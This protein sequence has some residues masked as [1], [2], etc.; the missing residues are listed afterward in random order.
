METGRWTGK[1][2]HANGGG[3]NSER[4]AEAFDRI[5]LGNGLVDEIDVYY[6]P[7]TSKFWIPQKTGKLGWVPITRD[8]L[9]RYLTE[10]HQIPRGK[11]QDR[12]IVAI[13]QEHPVKYAG[14]LAGRKTGLIRTEEG[15]VLVTESYR[16]IPPR[17]GDWTFIRQMLEGRLG[18]DVEQLYAWLKLSYENLRDEKLV[19]GLL[20]CLVGPPDMHKTCTQELVVS[21]VLGWRTA[22]PESYFSHRTDFNGEFAAAEHL[23]ISDKEAKSDNSVFN[24][25][26]KQFCGSASQRIHP[27]YKDAFRTKV[28]WRPTLSCN[29]TYPDILAL[30]DLNNP[31]VAD[32]LLALYFCGAKFGNWMPAENDRIA[33][34]VRKALPGFIHY[35]TMEFEVREELFD[36][37]FGQKP[38]VNQTVLDKYFQVT[39][40]ASVLELID[41]TFFTSDRRGFTDLKNRPR[42]YIEG[43]ATTLV[44]M[45][46]TSDASREFQRLGAL[47]PVTLGTMLTSVAQNPT[48]KHRIKITMRGNKKVYRIFPPSAGD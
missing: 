15:L 7:K 47:N 21:G 22:A 13:I 29:D 40:E 12:Y 19:P 30:P 9:V 3:G 33:K 16:L 38:Y 2:R 4:L 43:Y 18:E 34:E 1:A 44:Q 6:E 31:T 36:K 46:E 8:D 25:R 14:P 27:K 32:K 11:Q 26:V 37:R 35:L 48:T 42:E 20:L 17:K 10:K 28:F 39:H 24:S 45:L 41:A 5:G 23:I